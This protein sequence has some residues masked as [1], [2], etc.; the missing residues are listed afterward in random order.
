[1]TAGRSW[2]N[3]RRRNRTVFTAL[4]VSFLFFYSC[5]RSTIS[6]NIP[7]QHRNTLYCPQNPIA[8]EVL[9]VL[10]TGATE[11]LEKLPVHFDTTLRC[12]PN[13]AIYSDYEEDIKGSH[14]HDVFDEISHDLQQLVPDFELY[15]RLKT[16]GR[17]GLSI[18]GTE[19]DGSGPSGLLGNPGWKLDKFKF[20]PMI[21]KALRHR[22]QAKW[23]VF[24]ELDTYLMW[25]NLLEYLSK[26]NA[27]VPYYI[28][29]QMY[30][31]EVLF[32]HGGSG[33]ALSAPAMRRVT[34]HWR[35]HMVEYNQYTIEQWA[36]DMVLGKALKDV[37]VPLLW[38]FPHFQGDP[39]STLDHNITKIDRRP[40]C[41]PAITYHHMPEDE[42]RLLWKFEQ[43]WQRTHPIDAPLRH[44]D[45]FKGYI[46][47]YLSK[48]RA[49]WDNYS[50]NPEFS[51]T[52]LKNGEA[53]TSFEACR[54]AC[55]SNPMCLQFSYRTSMCLVS[56]EVRLGRMATLQCSEYS[57]AASKCDKKEEMAVGMDEEGQGAVRS[58]WM[59]DRV[60]KYVSAMDQTCNPRMDWIV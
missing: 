24:I 32:A 36:G 45:V 48:E 8:K 41:Y 3:F 37:L 56:S 11:V 7:N 54:S 23:F 52:A 50:V 2:V 47:P 57:T 4:V 35:A 1:M 5:Q 26:F 14:I 55:E 60:A 15:H 22:P 29:K 49:E 12:I 42:I 46:H 51:K 20:L 38:A 44:A 39:V 17:D 16:K 28:G 53:H 30:I 25:G 9:V 59:V 58:G 40:W 31:G 33:F 18:D 19:H 21:D 27:E 13:Y 34:E 6:T 10:R 43:E